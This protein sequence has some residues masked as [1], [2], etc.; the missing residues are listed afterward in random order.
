MYSEF[1]GHLSSSILTLPPNIHL[2]YDIHLTH[3]VIPFCQMSS[4]ETTVASLL[5]G[6]QGGKIGSQIRYSKSVF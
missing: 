4:F 6:V 3:A 5:E 1:A 2:T